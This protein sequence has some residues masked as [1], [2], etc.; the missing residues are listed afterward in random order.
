MFTRTW[1]RRLFARTPH[2]RRKEPARFRPRLEAL[3]GR[4]A[5]A[6]LTVNST[7]DNT[8]DTSV[9]TLREAIAIVNTSPDVKTLSQ[10]IQNQISGALHAGKTDTIQFDPTKVTGAITLGG[11]Q[12]ELSLPSS[13]AA[14]TIDGGAAGVTV[15]GNQA[16]RIFRVDKGVQASLEDLTL[17]HGSAGFGGGID[18]FGTLTVSN[19]T[20]SGN[21]ATDHDGGGIYND[22]TLTVSNSTLSGNSATYGGGIFEDSAGKTDLATTLTLNNT[23]VAHVA[24]STGGDIDNNGTI[25]GSHNLVDDG[26][27]GLPDTIQADPK[28]DP[29]GL[30]NNGGPTQTLALQAGSPALTKGDS[31]LLPNDPSTGKPYA[32]DQRGPGF[33]RVVNGQMDIGAYQVQP[34]SISPDSLQAGTYGTAYTKTITAAEAGFSSFTFSVPPGTLPP[35]LSLDSTTGTL[36]GTPAAANALP[37]TFTVTAKDVN[38]FTASQPY[39]LLINQAPATTAIVSAGGTYTG[40]PLAATGTVTGAGGLSTAPSSFL[41]VGTGSTSYGLS[42]TPPTNAGTYSVTATYAGDANHAGSSSAQTPFTIGQAPLTITAKD[43]TIIQGEA[44]P[45][46]FG[47][48]YS[49]FVPGEGPGVLGGT[50]TFTLTATGPTTY[51]IKPGGLTATNYQIQFASGTLTVLSW[52]QATANLLKQVNDAK[53]PNGAGLDQGLKN[54]LD[55]KLQ[56]AIA[57]FNQGNLTAAKNQLAAFLN[58]V[59]AQKG[60]GIDDGLAKTLSDSALEILNAIG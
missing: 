13:T 26:S 22:G 54:S 57:S 41:Y 47:L 24:N 29:K 59:S 9:L 27:D 38:G 58:E 18:N 11:T 5:P 56:A 48:S 19:C 53:Q 52:S 3:E 46:T 7:A 25:T 23:I 14:V 51:A 6:V 30:Q 32:T 20:L 37:Y 15:D 45:T 55:S 31:S 34:L 33:P 8:T 1:I 16:S 21:S 49:G 12:L 35:G 40:Q 60:K 36:S 50:P 28:L 2:T 4:L 10:S 42:A 17:K 44:L 43:A 39:N